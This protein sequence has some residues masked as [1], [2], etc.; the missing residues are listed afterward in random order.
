MRVNEHRP[1]LTVNMPLE[2]VAT[3]ERAQ[4]ESTGLRNR[5]EHI[6]RMR[7]SDEAYQDAFVDYIGAYMRYASAL[8]RA[9]MAY[10]PK[11]Y[12]TR[13]YIFT[14]DYQTCTMLIEEATQ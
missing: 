3:I 8:E 11:Q 14:I 13:D 1:I 12:R 10:V 7:L 5:I 4:Y 9:R 6:E 2:E